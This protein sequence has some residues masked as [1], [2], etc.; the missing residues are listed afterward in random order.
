MP[1]TQQKISLIK[2]TTREF[3]NWIDDWE[4]YHRHAEP[5]MPGCIFGDA[6]ED[7]I[8]PPLLR[9]CGQDR[10]QETK[11]GIVQPSSK[12]YVTEHDYVAAAHPWL[13][14]VKDKLRRAMNVY[15]D[16]ELAPDATLMVCG[17]GRDVVH[18]KDVEGWKFSSMS[19]FEL[20]QH[21]N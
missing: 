1:L 12:P 15:E 20:L 8:E 4:E 14:G 11:P 7:D 10:P 19:L 3:S 17:Q 5:G 6:E 2:V 18:I 16:G 13:L 9:C 21:Y